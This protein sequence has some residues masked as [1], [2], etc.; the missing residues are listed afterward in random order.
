MPCAMAASRTVAF[1]ASQR[2]RADPAAGTASM[3]SPSRPQK[4]PSL[5]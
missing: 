5:R 4:A 2:P 1:T 3:I